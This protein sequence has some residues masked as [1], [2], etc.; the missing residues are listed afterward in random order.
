MRRSIY[1]CPLSRREILTGS[2]YLVVHIFLLPSLLPYFFYHCFPDLYAR[3]DM[4][5]LNC[6]YYLISFVAVFLLLLRFLKESFYHFCDH[7]GQGILSVFSGYLVQWV[8]NMALSLLLS[9]VLAGLLPTTTP[10]NPNTDSLVGMADYNRG[11]LIASAVTLAP[12]VEE[13]LF[14]GV[15]F[16]GLRRKNRYLAYIV[17][18]LLFAVYH[19]WQYFVLDYSPWLFLSLLDYLPVS[20]ALAWSYEQGG[21]IWTPIF[22]HMFLNAVSLWVLL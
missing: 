5:T 6:I 21:S 3:M 4:G 12:M 18:Y 1:Y 10:A 16:G 13:P 20:I 7:K 19:L 15:V 11:A 14:R 8:V 17:S 22:L 2:I 9:A